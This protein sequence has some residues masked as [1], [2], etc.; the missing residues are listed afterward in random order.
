MLSIVHIVLYLPL[1]PEVVFYVPLLN[2]TLISANMDYFKCI[3]VKEQDK[4]CLE[5]EVPIP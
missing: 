5:Q 1:L 4:Y 2:K 3:G